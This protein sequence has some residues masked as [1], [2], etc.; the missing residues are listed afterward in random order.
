[1]TG[2]KSAKTILITSCMAQEGKSFISANVATSFAE[3]GKRVLLIDSDMRKGRLSK[4]FDIDNTSGLSNY[5][6]SITD[7][8]EK[9]L[10]LG[11]NYIKETKVPNLHIL[12]NGNVPPNPSEL[13]VSGGMQKLTS[14]LGKIY[15]II[16][17]DA[18]PCLLVTDSIILSTITDGT[19]LVAN[20][21]KTKINEM[22][23]V[24][25]SI[26]IVG[27]KII[28]AI[29]NKV[30]IIEK[31]YSKSYYYEHN[32][33]NEKCETRQKGIIPVSE[34]L[35]IDI[36]KTDENS[37][38]KEIEQK[39]ENEINTNE[40]T[41]TQKQYFEKVINVLLDINTQLTNSE[42]KNNARIEQNRI[43]IEELIK[44]EINK[45]EEIKEIIKQEIQNIDYKKALKEINNKVEELKISYDKLARK[46]EENQNNEEESQNSIMNK[47]IIDI[48]LFKKQKKK[49]KSYSIKQDINYKDLEESAFCI[50]PFASENFKME[51][52][53]NVSM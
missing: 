7:D 32:K 48:K 18:P 34:L 28:G 44:T 15:D 30:N 43:E 29:L 12:P 10:E 24:K 27:G 45:K 40:F 33:E 20:S 51:N 1:M 52:Y 17:I 23:Q 47:N 21:R 19:I 36:P 11:K 3:T 42:K 2:V 35:N 22:I 49:K 14:L 38:K 8:I 5:L 9:D 53:R 50:I 16:I 6:Y 46:I 37:Q 39:I 26:Q 4:I 31:N 41:D 13:L 25:K